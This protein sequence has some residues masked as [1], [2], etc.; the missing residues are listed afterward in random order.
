MKILAL[1]G[2]PTS[3]KLWSRL[4]LRRGV[5]LSAPWVPGLGVSGTPDHWS[6]EWAA[7]LLRSE[8]DDADLIV[9]HDL[10]GVLAAMLARDGQRVVLSGTALGLYWAAIRVTAWPFLSRLFYHRHAGRRFLSRG[11]LPEHRPGLVAAFGDHGEVWAERM[12]WGAWAM[13]PPRGL[14]AS[15]QRTRVDLI[16]GREDPWYPLPVARRLAAQTGARLHLLEAGHFAP[17]EAP[18]SFGE[19]LLRDS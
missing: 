12:R 19:V 1:H 10:G 5:R 7:D 2:L 17:W 6:L 14:A 3:P 8:A 9:G 11:C 18:T 16:W 4:A 13:R 15:L